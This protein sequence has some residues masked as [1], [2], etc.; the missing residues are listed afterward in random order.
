[1]PG[2][3]DLATLLRTMRPELQ[4]GTY[5][6]C[7]FPDCLPDGARPLMTFREREGITAIL[8][9]SQAEALGIAA[10]FPSA[11]ITLNVHS[12]LEAVGLLAAVAREL[13]ANGISSNAVSAYYHDHLFV[14]VA[15]G[16]RVV[17]ILQRLSSG[18]SR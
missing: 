10:V 11:W 1:M 9:Q 18:D 8:E 3:T 15:D 16:P 2:E 12:A 5:V 6:F 4:P 14:P 13:A 17:E 7:N